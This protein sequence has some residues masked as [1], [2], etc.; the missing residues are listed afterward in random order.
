MSKNNKFADV[1]GFTLIVAGIAVVVIEAG[2]VAAIGVYA[3]IWG[4][5][6]MRAR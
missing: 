4:N 5:N 6:V 2:W 3:L 1:F